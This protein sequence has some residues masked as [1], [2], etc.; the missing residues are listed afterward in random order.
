MIQEQI[1]D[2]IRQIPD[3]KLVEVYDLIHYFRLGLL[4]E[5]RTQPA[6]GERYPLRGKP[7][8]FEEPAEPVALEDWDVLK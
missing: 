5:K 1:I 2:E 7:I 3:E 6:T 4:H 8:H